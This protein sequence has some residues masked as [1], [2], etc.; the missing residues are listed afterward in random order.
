MS[1]TGAGPSNLSACPMQVVDA[2]TMQLYE[3]TM[4]AQEGVVYFLLEEM[5]QQRIKENLLAYTLLLSRGL[6]PFRLSRQAPAI[7]HCH[8]V[9]MS[10][11]LLW[12]SMGL[13]M[14]SQAACAGAGAPLTQRQLDDACEAHLQQRFGEKLDFAVENSLPFLL[15]DGLVKETGDVRAPLPMP[16]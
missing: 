11:V 3:Q 16:S 12:R 1:S 7:I 4:D 5:A 15:H 10:A 9:A 8:S 6:P 14:G 2:I 13:R